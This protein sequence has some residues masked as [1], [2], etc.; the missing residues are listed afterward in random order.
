MK[1]YLSN[2]ILLLITVISKAQQKI[3]STVGDAK[4]SGG[5]AVMQ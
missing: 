3:A 5:S 1:K 2:I 4:G